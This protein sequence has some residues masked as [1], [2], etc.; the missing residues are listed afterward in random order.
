MAELIYSRQKFVS[1][2]WRESEGPRFP[3]IRMRF[4]HTALSYPIVS[5]RILSYPVVSRIAY[6]HSIMKSLR[7]VS[8]VSLWLRLLL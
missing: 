8:V 3:G 4:V 7:I 6:D 2:M 5:Y 1:Y